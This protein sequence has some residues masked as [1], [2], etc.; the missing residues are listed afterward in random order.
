MLWQ[1]V[2]ATAA[3]SLGTA[4]TE[5][6]AGAVPTALQANGESPYLL[7]SAALFFEPASW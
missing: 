6:G 5:T 7:S 3:G 4:S 1:W 2:Q